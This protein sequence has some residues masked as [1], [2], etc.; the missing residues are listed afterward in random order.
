MADPT[1]TPARIISIAK[2]PAAG[3]Y[4]SQYVR[5]ARDMPV[6]TWS[7]WDN[8]QSVKAAMR[9]LE[10]GRLDSAALVVDAMGRD[11][12][13]SGVLG[14]R[15]GALP[16]LPIS[17]VKQGDKRRAESVAN[18][19]T[20]NFEA[21]F[22]DAQLVRLQQAG[23]MLGA[24]LGQLVWDFGETW[25]PRL[26]VWHSRFLSWNQ[27]T[28][29]YWVQTA[30]G[31]V[32]VVPGDGQWIL[33][34]P[35]GVDQGWMHG[36]VRSLYVPWLIRQWGLRDMAR[37]AEVHGL[38]IK[39]GYIPASASGE[40][41]DKFIR[42]L[43]ALSSESTIALPGVVGSGAPG[44]KSNYDVELLEAMGDSSI[45]FDR[46][47]NRADACIAVN[48][49]GQN[50]TT[51]VKAGSFAAAV[52]HMAI[53]NDILTADAEALG[54]C[55]KT[56]AL[57]WYCH[58]NFGDARLAPMPT[59]KTRPPDDYTAKGNAYKAVGE[60]IAALELVGYQVDKDKVADAVELPTTGP[61]QESK[62]PAAVGVQPGAGEGVRPAPGRGGSPAM[63]RPRLVKATQ[64]ADGLPESAI[65]GQL[66]ADELAVAGTE[67]GAQVLAPDLRALLSLVKAAPTPEA[68]QE[69]LVAHYGKMSSKRLAKLLKNT[70]LLGEL[71]GRWAVTEE[72]MEDDE[73]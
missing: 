69:S 47:L 44:E 28:R 61:A 59:W 4:P 41:R 46:L 58:M 55:I 48:L 70:L 30:E 57:S 71:S 25:R 5:P 31:P 27:T 19:L 60:G 50:L 23:I 43:T 24:G 73:E 6:L 20:E 49:L 38:P 52:A 3:A 45:T 66:F 2:P 16:S 29:S 39:K 53:R 7:E 32:E 64:D 14:T 33:F 54:E 37:N 72:L 34:A 21:M 11:D 8:V 10:G 17:F 15:C 35:Y 67:A 62:P 42:D 18:D 36:H 12:R 51:E 63:P 13:I 40:D 9:S 22:P 26:K 65:E 68:L 56:Q 1:S